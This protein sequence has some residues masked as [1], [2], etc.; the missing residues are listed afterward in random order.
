MLLSLVMRK[1]DEGIRVFNPSSSQRF[2]EQVSML[3][4]MKGRGNETLRLDK[5]TRDRHKAFYANP[6]DYIRG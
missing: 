5:K 6:T 1:R 4:E 2:T 3:E